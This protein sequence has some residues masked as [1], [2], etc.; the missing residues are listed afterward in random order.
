MVNVTSRQE[1]ANVI[2][3]LLLF[4][5]TL[6]TV[7]VSVD[8][9]M[10]VLVSVAREPAAV[11]LA[12]LDPSASAELM[13]EPALEPMPHGTATLVNAAVEES[14]LFVASIL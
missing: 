14:M 6:Q 11:Q 10:E 12:T 7:P 2:L 5:T 13:L 4:L 3:P 1:L 9:S 8:V